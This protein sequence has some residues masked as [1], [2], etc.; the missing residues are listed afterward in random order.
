MDTV[1]GNR[2]LSLRPSPK[3]SRNQRH[4]TNC[5]P[6]KNEFVAKSCGYAT[7]EY[8]TV[9]KKRLFAQLNSSVSFPNSLNDRIGLPVCADTLRASDRSGVPV[10]TGEVTV[11]L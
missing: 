2:P 7:F 4:Q 8:R 5:L 6:V 10:E 1:A 9:R 11:S 3:S